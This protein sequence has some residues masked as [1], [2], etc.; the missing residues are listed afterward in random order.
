MRKRHGKRR[1]IVWGA[2]LCGYDARPCRVGGRFACFLC[3]LN[4]TVVICVG[5]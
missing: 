5:V 4:A 2:F 3:D 1:D